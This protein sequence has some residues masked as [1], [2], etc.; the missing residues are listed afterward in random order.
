MNCPRC[1]ALNIMVDGACAACGYGARSIARRSSK[2]RRPK[3]STDSWR[4]IQTRI[5]ELHNR[6]LAAIRS[7][8]RPLTDDELEQ[9]L[10]LSHQNVSARTN[11]LRHARKLIASGV[12]KRT[13]QG[14]LAMAWALAEEGAQVQQ[15]ALI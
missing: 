11:E 7:A 1:H 4:E 12:R 9:V 10:R 5:G 8:G 14:G 15:P 3:T 2:P 13:R 6:I